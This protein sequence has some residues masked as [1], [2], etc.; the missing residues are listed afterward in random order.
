MEVID[1]ECLSF[2]RSGGVGAGVGAKIRGRIR[3]GWRFCG[4][5]VAFVETLGAYLWIW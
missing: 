5:A 3:G 2:E 4:F 1:E